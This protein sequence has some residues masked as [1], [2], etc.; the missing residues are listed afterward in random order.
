[1]L[2]RQS[3]MGFN[4]SQDMTKNALEVR[5]CMDIAPLDVAHHE[6]PFC[7][8]FF[9]LEGPLESYV[10]DQTGYRL[11]PGDVLI[12]P[13]Y[14]RHHPVFTAEKSGPYR[15]YVLW[16]SAEQLELMAALDTGLVSIL[17]YCRQGKNYRIRSTLPSVRKQLENYLTDMWREALSESSCQQASL[18]SLCLQFFVMLNRVIADEQVLP[19]SPTYSDFLLEVVLDYIN[20][21]FAEPLSLKS[22][23][24]RFFTSPSNIEMLF[25]RKVQCPFYRYVT[26]CRISHAQKLILSNT[27]LKEV[28]T[29][30]GYNDYS[31]FYRAFRKVTGLSPAQFRD[32]ALSEL[33]QP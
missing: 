13:P 18:Y 16:I 25:N 29:A 9:F 24:D 15:R 8:V 28:S 30:C 27:S 20:K 5:Y 21:N 12:I 22:V 14:V 17:Q 33:K 4:P 31:N 11:Q 3:P 32:N 10:V 23:A 19:S 7:E 26:E 6:H 2:E 1:M